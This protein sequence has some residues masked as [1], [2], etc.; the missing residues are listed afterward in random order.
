[1]RKWAW[2]VCK[3]SSVINRHMIL[4]DQSLCWSLYIHSSV[5]LT[6]L[7]IVGCVLRAV[8]SIFRVLNEKKCTYMKHVLYDCCRS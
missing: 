4:Q 1:M 6:V 5:V 2:A 3:D 7:K 8:Y